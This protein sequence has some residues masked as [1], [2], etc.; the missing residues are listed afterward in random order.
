L[1]LTCSF[2]FFRAD[3]MKLF[4]HPVQAMFLGAI[5]PALGTIVNGLP[6]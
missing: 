5:P 3:G 1:R 2:I 6:L 4:T